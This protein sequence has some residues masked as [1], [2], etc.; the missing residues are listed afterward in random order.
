MLTQTA[1]YALRAVLFLAGAPTRG[2]VSVDEIAGSL[3]VPASYLSKI[4]PELARAG[5]IVATRGRSGGYQ[6][7]RRAEEIPLSQVVDV[8]ENGRGEHRHCLL[9]R[10]PCSERTACSAHH[11]WKGTAER[12]ETFFRCTTIAD[13]RGPLEGIRSLAS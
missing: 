4:L 11:Q 2:P 6:L 10:G 1:E 9:G 12:I 13:I 7:A 8:F 5:V 3:E